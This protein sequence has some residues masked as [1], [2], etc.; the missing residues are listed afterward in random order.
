MAPSGNALRWRHAVLPVPS[1]ECGGTM[2]PSTIHALVSNLSKC[3]R[4]T[5]EL[6]PHSGRFHYGRLAPSTDG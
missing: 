5:A 4:A 3:L 6:G 1:S 2:H